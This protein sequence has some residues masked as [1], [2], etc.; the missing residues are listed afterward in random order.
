MIFA[1]LKNIHNKMSIFFTH[2]MVILGG[3]LSVNASNVQAETIKV[4]GENCPRGYRLVSLSKVEVNASQYCGMIGRWDIV[5]LSGNASIS[6]RGY[7]CGLQTNDRRGLGNALCEKRVRERRDTPTRSTL[8]QVLL[9]A[10]WRSS[11]S[12]ARMTETNKRNALITELFKRSDSTIDFLRSKSNQT[13]IEYAEIYLSLVENHQRRINRIHRMSLREQRRAYHR[14]QPISDACPAMVE[15]VEGL[16]D[17][18][19]YKLSSKK[20]RRIAQRTLDHC[21][22]SDRYH[23]DKKKEQD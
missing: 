21:N 15:F 16:A 4:N 22:N 12:L 14:N 17:G 23:K 7:N 9:D 6:G 2:L 10:D 20:M 19:F 13:L 18:E 1:N 8:T 11:R 5:R 3:V